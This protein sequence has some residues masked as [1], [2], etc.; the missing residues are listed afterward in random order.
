MRRHYQM[1]TVL[2][3]SF[4]AFS[5]PTLAASGPRVEVFSPQG[6]VKSVRQV[7]VR[8]SSPMTSLGD[9]R[10]T[11]PFDIDCAAPGQGRWADDRNWV[12][13]FKSDLAG[14]VQCTFM[15]KADAK[16]LNGVRVSAKSSYSFNT[17]GP[18]IRQ[19]TPYEGSR[20]IDENQVFFLGLDAPADPKSV[21][22]NTYC[23][24]EGIEE[25]IPVVVLS[26]EE[27]EKAFVDLRTL[28]Y[29]YNSLLREGDGDNL[30]REDTVTA[31]KC[32]R[33]LPPQTKTTLVW[34]A[35]IAAPSGLA[36]TQDQTLQFRT[37]PTFTARFS[38]DR[39]NADAPC[40]PMMDMA[41]NFSAP[42]P[43]KMAAQIALV[44]EDQSRQLAKL[45][46]DA[47]T[48]TISRVIFD[49]PFA[50]G[51]SYR[52]ELP[53]DLHDDSGRTLQ[54]AERFPLAVRTDAFPPLIKFASEFGIIESRAGAVLPVTV[55]NV[56]PRIQAQ[57]KSLPDADIPARVHRATDVFAMLEWMDKAKKAGQWRGKWVDDAAGN[58]VYHNNTG[59]RSIFEKDT[60]SHSFNVPR[61]EGGKAFEV[62]GIPLSDPGFYAVELQS[63]ALGQALLGRD[64][65][66]YVS[67]T[68]LVTNM[69]VHFLWG[70]EGSLIWVT[71]LDTGKPVVGANV[72]IGDTCTKDVIWTGQTG[73]DGTTRVDAALHAPS[74][75]GSCYSDEN[76]PLVIS[77]AQ[78]E[79]FSFTLSKWNDGIAPYD[80][81][82]SS[83]SLWQ[84]DMAHTVF[85]RTLLRAG[86][87][88]S[89]KHYLRRHTANGFALPA[90]FT[91]KSTVRISH[92]ATGQDVEIPV[93]F[94][95][96]G[97]ALSQYEIP[98]E[99]RLGRYSVMVKLGEDWQD[100]GSFRVEEFRLPTM[101]AILQGPDL[102]LVGAADMPLDIMVRYLS[103]GGASGLGIKV[104]TVVR[105]TPAQFADYDEYSFD[106]ETLDGQTSS[107]GQGEDEGSRPAT[108]LTPA[109]LD[110]DGALRLS[111]GDLPQSE[112]HATLTTEL[113]YRDANGQILTKAARFDLWPAAQVVGIK[114]EGWAASIDKLKLHTIALNVD[115]SPAAN[116]AIDVKAFARKSYSYRK[117]LIGGFYSYENVTR[118]EPLAIG[119]TGRSNANGV[120]TCTLAP[121][122]S[123]EVILQASTTD[124]A[125]RNARATTS[126][127]V[128]GKDDWW[129]SGSDGDRMDL[130][131]ENTEYDG[132]D[133]AK[134]Q[135]RSPFRSATAL[136]TIEREG[137]IDSFVTVISGKTPVID[138]P[139]KAEYAPNVYVS[140]LAI[141]GR[142][143]AWQS[144]LSDFVRKYD[145][146]W[147]SRDGGKATALIDLAKPAY[148][149]GLA[150]MR[151]GWNAH[152]L[153][154]KVETDKSVYRIRENAKATITLTRANGEALP[155]GSEIAIAVV[156]EAL[157]QLSPNTSWDL[158][159]AMMDERGL[160]VRTSTAQMQIIGKRHYGRKAVAHGGGGGKQN[161]RE[162]FDTLLLW[163]GRVVVDED[164]KAQVDIPLND[165]LSA[166]RV[167]AIAQNGLDLFGT[168]SQKITTT[169]DLQ[170]LSGLPKVVRENDRFDAVFTVRNASD[171]DMSVIVGG[172]VASL[173]P[174]AEQNLDIPAGTARSVN[175]D[176]LVPYDVA[177][178]TW[179]IGVSEENGGATDALKASQKVDPAI[180]VRVFQSTL[181]QLDAPW[182][183]TLARPNDAIQG[184]GG[185]DVHL[186]STL[187]GD[188]SGVKDYMRSYPY[189]CFEQRT[190][191][192]IAL[193]DAERWKNTAR[194]LPAY[195][196][197][198]GLV[199]Y[200]PSDYLRGS[201]TLTAYVLSITHEAGWE[202]PEAQRAQMLDGLSAFIN[203]RIRRGSPLD[204]ADLTVRKLAAMAA[205]SRYNRAKAQMLTSLNIN[206]NLLPTSAVLDWMN[207]LRRVKTIPA[208]RQG[209][210]R[211]KQVL[212][213]RLN[214]QGTHMGF[215][216]E[217]QDNLWWLMI[218]A[219]T[220]AA[221]ALI[222]LSDAP[223]W[224]A[225]MPRMARGL[226]GRQSNGHWRTT[227]GNAWGTLAMRQFSAR[228]ENTKVSGQS[229]AALGNDRQ[230]QNWG[231]SPALDFALPWGNG[232]QSLTLSHGGNG[233]PWAFVTAKAAI[234]LRQPLSSGYAITRTMSPISQ[235]VPGAWNVG[236]VVRIK[237]EIDA[238]TDMTWVVVDDPVPAGAQILGGGLGGDS[239]LLASGEN[240]TGRA[241]PVYE[242]RRFASYQAFYRYVP[243]GKFTLE[244]TIRLNTKGDFNLP[245]TRVEAMYAPEMFGEV[246][247]AP[248]SVSATGP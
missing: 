181:K 76:H 126:I 130:L 59:D 145:L 18:N 158:L 42:I 182:S 219:D 111:I 99:A 210:E 173:G 169:Q 196:D 185:V 212:R 25:R 215:S 41:L 203:G 38:C 241:W 208:R 140:V 128:A 233:A 97:S 235:A 6:T 95:A 64:A 236:D 80:F 8:F 239:A 142:V 170:I 161:A 27:R 209:I 3:A 187:G 156:D 45:G 242:E 237:L 160:E 174:L 200:F 51:A 107:T 167:V 133:I 172:R 226:L 63:K 149:L 148:R 105:K 29:R 55:R 198:D 246:P 132:G 162:I 165:S 220:N 98:K 191:M 120:F 131:V 103:G 68:A 92:D 71:A 112:T 16:A 72:S 57:L 180:P 244:Y 175:W 13:D 15:L 49:A 125:G 31:L 44:G 184:R 171:H 28:G 115:G 26:G 113:E 22:A 227:T 73:K 108:S 116:S 100:A 58:S 231:D 53:Q 217:A 119:C 52:I 123:G 179:D 39:T 247:I 104:R 164:G 62:I 50:P 24:V 81:D 48:P 207:I 35:G 144:W 186:Q 88:V 205:L 84:A 40:L 9:P 75:W 19:T 110:D 21:S 2:L 150:N 79:D 77:A 32:Q 69:A 141:R 224:R 82:I 7:A 85:D 10:Q 243:K 127:W 155:A 206:P 136:V 228:F 151:V 20:R 194:A 14:G 118:I 222:S 188:L 157:L 30:A 201:D 12:Y 178:L 238:Q 102:P 106:A 147:F 74:G 183:L 202:I 223:L 153:N 87:T 46:D 159:K 109:N 122:Q 163:Q 78:G 245:P 56:E 89:M 37:R 218:S 216:T 43:T 90:D 197:N 229:S 176:I 54:N 67:T 17:G 177:S 134:V 230:T 154:V 221:R 195:L 91:P 166:F 11:N 214:F 5:G 93:M 70:R 33:T 83:S 1:I 23:A 146:P 94:D 225:D 213:A 60:S 114:T 66:R 129:F 4:L 204:T 117:R 193:N 211:A 34:G 36:T 61:P 152:R 96:N 135:V 143:G 47:D 190:S 232:P 234:P 101:E 121:G 86:E 65:S 168:G 240:N 124:K 138:V 199:K 248:L 137:V 192:A 189:R 139:I